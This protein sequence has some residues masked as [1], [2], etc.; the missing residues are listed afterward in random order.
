MNRVGNQYDIGIVDFRPIEV[1]ATSDEHSG[2]YVF[3]VDPD[4]LGE[5]PDWLNYSNLV[6][7]APLVRYESGFGAWKTAEMK[8]HVP[9]NSLSNDIQPSSYIID[10]TKS[11]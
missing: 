2:D 10:S 5:V 3:E 4:N 6:L 9:G 11:L 7:S 8:D 1:V